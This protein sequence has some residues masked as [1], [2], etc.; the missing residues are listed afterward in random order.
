MRLRRAFNPLIVQNLHDPVPLCNSPTKMDGSLSQ[1]RTEPLLLRQ[2]IVGHYERNVTKTWKA[3]GAEGIRTP[4]PHN[5][6]VVK[7]SVF[8]KNLDT[9]E[10]LRQICRHFMTICRLFQKDELQP[11]P[12]GTVIQALPGNWYLLN[13]NHIEQKII[14]LYAAE[15]RRVS[16]AASESY[17]VV[18]TEC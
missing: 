9:S 13:P 17:A 5:A 1:S 4:D 7:T 11:V 8:P 12:D 14:E 18:T 2:R 6:I 16:A 3:G 15:V 10:N